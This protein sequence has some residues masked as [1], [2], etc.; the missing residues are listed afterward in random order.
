M[1]FR[2]RETCLS[3]NLGRGKDNSQ[4]FI[5]ESV[6]QNSDSSIAFSQQWTEKCWTRETHTRRQK[7]RGTTVMTP[8]GKKIWFLKKKNKSCLC[9]SFVDDFS[10]FIYVAF[11]L[12]LKWACVELWNNC[13]NQSL[14]LRQTGWQELKW[15]NRKWK[16]KSSPCQ[17]YKLTREELQKVCC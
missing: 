13:F 11:R 17:M 15:M 2:K 4:L 3:S 12:L 7:V 5:Q 10:V 14:F 8:T 9:C 6:S 16:D 1:G